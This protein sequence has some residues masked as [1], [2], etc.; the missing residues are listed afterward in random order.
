MEPIR[1]K[2][3]TLFLLLFTSLLLSCGN[4]DNSLTTAQTKFGIF[5][6]SNDQTSVE[7]NGEISSASLTNFNALYAAYPAVTKINIKNCG[8]SSDDEINLVLSK[9]VFDLNIETHLLDNGEI[10]SGGVDFFV[11]GKKRTK[12]EST[13]IGVHSWSGGANQASDFPVGH[14]NHLPY[15]NYYVSVGFTQ[16]QAE[17]FYYFT[18]NAAPASG[19]HWMTEAEIATYKILKN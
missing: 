18:I 2:I 12:G 11:A 6:I 4:N 15:I 7:M 13:K 16:Q 5:T 10:A 14:A 8:G 3:K 9:R 1:D 19:I 17:D